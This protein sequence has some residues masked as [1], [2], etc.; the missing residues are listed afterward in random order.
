ME[1]GSRGKLDELGSPSQPSPQGEG[2]IR[3]KQIRIKQK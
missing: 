2:F 3:V 1:R